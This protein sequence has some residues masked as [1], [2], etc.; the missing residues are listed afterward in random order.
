M[1]R[2]HKEQNHFAPLSLASTSVYLSF[3]ID[4]WAGIAICEMR[5]QIDYKY[6][7]NY[8]WR[9]A[10]DLLAAFPCRV[11]LKNIIQGRAIMMSRS[12]RDSLLPLLTSASPWWMSACKILNL[13]GQ[14]HFRK[15]K[16]GIYVSCWATAAHH[17]CQI[18]PLVL[19]QELHMTEDM[20]HISECHHLNSQSIK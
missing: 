17:V 15:V 9:D 12:N 4:H 14:G 1:S 20:L 8:F 11:A 7:V 19:K 3:F 13:F 18:S 6:L 5:K 10:V 2:E 16:S